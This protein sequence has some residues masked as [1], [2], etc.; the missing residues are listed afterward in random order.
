MLDK[1]YAIVGVTCAVIGAAGY[2]L[3]GDAVKD[4]VT[5]NLPGGRC[6]R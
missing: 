4:E 5:L 1:T 2:A 6:P 3:W